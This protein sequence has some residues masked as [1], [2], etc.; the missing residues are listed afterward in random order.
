[1]FEGLGLRQRKVLGLVYIGSWAGGPRSSESGRRPPKGTALGAQMMKLDEAQIAQRTVFVTGPLI[2][3]E[4]G[5]LLPR[6][7]P[8]GE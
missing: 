5:L 4:A 2:K 1:M 6:P 8:S 3:P 7:Y